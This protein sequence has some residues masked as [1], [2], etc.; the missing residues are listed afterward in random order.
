[1]ASHE[2]GINAPV[3]VPDPR[4]GESVPSV[5]LFRVS[6]IPNDVRSTLGSYWNDVGTYL[7]TGD[8]SKLTPYEGMRVGGYQLVTDDYEL[9]F[10]ANDG[11]L[12]LDSIYEL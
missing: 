2:E 4:T 1:M 10:L 6:D 8:A 9:D 5:E 12:D 7:R 11:E 3:Y